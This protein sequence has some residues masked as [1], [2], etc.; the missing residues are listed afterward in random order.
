MEKLERKRASEKKFK[1]PIKSAKSDDKCFDAGI[2]LVCYQITTDDGAS[3]KIFIETD[4][5]AN[6]DFV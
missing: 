4:Q 6:C 2:I 1:R 5:L 3:H